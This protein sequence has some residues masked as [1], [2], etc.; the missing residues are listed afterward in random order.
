MTIG[1]IGGAFCMSKKIVYPEA[2]KWEAIRLR[3]EGFS[4]KEIQS[5]LGIKNISQVYTW[6]Y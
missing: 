1:T 3:E 2:V 6:W 4:V 5:Q